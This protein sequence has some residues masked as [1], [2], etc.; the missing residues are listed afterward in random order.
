MAAVA[1]IA[2]VLLAGIAI[3]FVVGVAYGVRAEQDAEVERLLRIERR[4]RTHGR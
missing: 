3:G 2:A 1:L 4:N